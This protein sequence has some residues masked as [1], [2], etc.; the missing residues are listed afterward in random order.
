MTEKNHTLSGL[1]INLFLTGRPC[2][3][4]G[5]GK[6]ATRKIQMLLE[7]GAKVAVVSPDVCGELGGLIEHGQ[8]THTVRRFEDHDIAG[9]TLVYAATNSRGINR[10]VLEACREKGILCCCVDG[11]WAQSDF[12]TP[13]TARHDN[14]LL[15]VSSGGN[16]CRQSKMVKNSLA[17]HLKMMDS[18][19][20]VVVGTDHNHLTVEEREPFHLTGHKFERAGFMIMQLWGIHE[21]MVL[22][23]C[24][25][26][27]VIAVVSAETAENGIL[28]HIMGFTQ[29]KEDKY[30]LKTGREA[31]EHLCLVTAGMLSQTPGENHITAQIKEALE[32]AKMRGWTGNMMQEWISSALFVSKAIKNEVSPLLHNYEIED[33]ALRYLE[34]HGKELA[35]STLMVLGAGMVGKGLVKDSLS[36]VGKIIWC[37]HVNKPDVPADWNGKVELCTFNDMKNRITDADT[38]VSATDAPGHILHMAHAPFFNQERPVMVIDLGM[39]RNIDPELDDLSSDVTVVDLDGLKYWYRRELTDINEVLIRS[40]AIAAQNKELYEKIA[41]SFKGGHAAE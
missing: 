9:A 17:R 25:R 7:A 16:D 19:H 20:L 22:N 32:T 37:Y 40:R 26:V 33:L 36:R 18:A 30:Y 3:V 31:F 28:R 10:N 24:N 41:N 1:H 23:T 11:N 35:Q 34:A 4:V 27:E 6:V 2:L 38:I 14:L 15:S 21:F 39:P 5:G 13:A 29:L 8:V 12:S